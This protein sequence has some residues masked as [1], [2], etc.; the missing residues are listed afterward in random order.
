M[1]KH[2]F[3]Y[4]LITISFAGF[5]E[6]DSGSPIEAYKT[7]ADVYS[8]YLFQF[9]V[10]TRISESALVSVHFPDEFPVF[11]DSK[12]SGF[13]YDRQTKTLVSCSKSNRV[14]T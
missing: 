2:L 9:G 11:T 14:V 6:P 8:I 10:E 7:N 5:I 3:H 4:L 1:L 13:A 12:C